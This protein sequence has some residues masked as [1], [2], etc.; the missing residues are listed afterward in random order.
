VTAAAGVVTVAAGVVTVAGGAVTVT[1]RTPLVDGEKAPKLLKLAVRGW[2]PTT[3]R[4]VVQVACPLTSTAAAAQPEILIPLSLKATD[5]PAGLDVTVAVRV[6]EPP[7]TTGLADAVSA[8]D[9]GTIDVIATPTGALPT[10]IAAPAVPAPRSIGVTVP[11][12]M[13]ATYATAPSPVIAIP[14]GNLPTGIGVP[15][16]TDKAASPVGT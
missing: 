10:V 11:E 4:V 12:P 7:A 2:G 6:N 13:L 9:V 15:R 16:S 14:M 3:L 5:P 1:T 8:V